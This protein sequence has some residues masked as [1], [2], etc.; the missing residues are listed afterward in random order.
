MASRIG[1][2]A[3]NWSQ[4]RFRRMFA[5]AGSVSVFHVSL[6]LLIP[7]VGCTS[8]STAP[9]IRANKSTVNS[10]ATTAKTGAVERT[11]L[12]PA[13]TTTQQESAPM[14]SGQKSNAAKQ[15]TDVAQPTGPNDQPASSTTPLKN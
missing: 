4:R 10:T 3:S 6:V 12:K 5:H 2:N 7:A 13:S 8:K 15:E 11:V 1:S 14:S 9:D